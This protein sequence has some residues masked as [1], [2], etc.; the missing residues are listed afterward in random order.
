LGILPRDSLISA[1]AK[2]PIKT[3]DR[4]T[5]PPSARAGCWRRPSCCPRRRIPHGRRPGRRPA[6]A[7]LRRAERAG[8]SDARSSTP[9]SHARELGYRRLTLWT[10]DALVSAR[11]IYQAAGFRLT[12]E[13]PHHSFGHDLVGQTWILDLI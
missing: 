6:E 3:T 9:A 4:L 8:A 1:V 10:N 7:S 11:R 2:V 13:A 5:R 12:H